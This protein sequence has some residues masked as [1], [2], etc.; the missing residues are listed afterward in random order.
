MMRFYQDS[1]RLEKASVV[2]DGSLWD[3]LTNE[4]KQELLQI[5]SETDSD[6]NLIP[7]QAIKNKYKKW[8]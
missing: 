2:K 4:E 7:L 5:D 1:M 8:L 3:R 6:D